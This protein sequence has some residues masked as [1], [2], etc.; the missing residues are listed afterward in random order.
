MGQL[1]KAEVWATWRGHLCRVLH[2][3]PTQWALE[4]LDDR[5]LVLADPKEVTLTEVRITMEW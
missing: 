5:P 4:L 3:S 1:T 2:K